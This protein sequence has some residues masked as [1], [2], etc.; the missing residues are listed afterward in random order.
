[1]NLRGPMEK[2]TLV[3]RRTMLRESA[4][5]SVAMAGGWSMGMRLNAQNITSALPRASAALVSE[6]MKDFSVP[7]FQLAYLRGAR[8]LYTGYFGEANRAEDQPVKPDSL[9]RIASDSKAF[10]SAAIFLLVEA[11]KLQLQ[12]R[13][14]A[15]D[16]V[17]RQFSGL[18]PHRE[19]IHAI[20]VH[21]LLTHTC[22]GWSNERNDPMFERP[23]LN[24]EQL[25][26]WTLK[27]H[28]LQNPP[29]EK[30]A[31]SNF[32]YCVLGRVIEQVSGE[33][34]PQFVRQQVMQRAGIHDMRIATRQPA[35]NEVHYYGQSGEN[36]YGFNISRMDSHGGWISTATDMARFLACLFSP[37]DDEGAPPILKPDSLRIM[38]TGTTA[39]PDYACGLAVNHAGNAWH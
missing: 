15:P 8:V 18:G 39:N 37:T 38:T 22:G 31:Y 6:Y 14:F 23:G 30:Y 20:T 33:R 21:E 3:S 29:G 2:Q 7:G 11:G 28:P 35:P 12:D 13:V 4:L 34:Y 26:A 36:P 16:G 27:T 10:T 5:A 19:W 17:L 9:F 32:G 24:H 1:M 25:I